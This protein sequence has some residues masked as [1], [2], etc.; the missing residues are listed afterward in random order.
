MYSCLLILTLYFFSAEVGISTVLG[1]A[2]LALISVY[3]LYYSSRYSLFWFL[4]ALIPFASE[5]RFSLEYFLWAAG[6]VGLALSSQWLN[7][8]ARRRE[9]T[10]F[11]A[12]I[13]FALTDY[14]RFIF[15]E[16]GSLLIWLPV[17]LSTI[18]TLSW[19][20]AFAAIAIFYTNKKAALLAYIAYLVQVLFVKQGRRY[21]RILLASG[22]LLVS[23]L[24]LVSHPKFL[25]KFYAQSIISRWH[26]WQATFS[27]FLDQAF[28]GH[29]FGTFAI[30]F[31]VYRQHADALGAR[32]AEHVAH[33]H[34]VPLHF[35]FEQGLV[36]LLLYLLLVVTIYSCQP[37]AL[38][39]F[40]LISFC[41][42][43]LVN[44][45]QYL[46]AALIL[47][48]KIHHQSLPVAIKQVLGVLPPRLL[49]PASYLAC[50]L[51]IVLSSFSIAAHYFYDRSQFTR[52]IA[53]DPYHSLYYF[54]RGASNLHLNA[55]I[56]E[57]D[58]KR[59]VE[60]SP[61]VSYF[62][63]FLAA[64]HLANTQDLS[65][66]SQDP[67]LKLASAAIK[68][69]VLY[70]GNDAYWH[71][72]SSFIHYQNPKLSKAEMKLALK[73]NPEIE[74]LLHEPSMTASEYIGSRKSDVRISGFYR[75]GPKVFL[76]LPY[77]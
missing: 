73:R 67:R 32:I 56:S 20:Q 10:L 52:A 19:H 3:G 60:L 55:A 53:L 47:L 74:S 26:I 27:G 28:I 25:A 43:S 4:L 58:L 11:V 36:G 39:P 17:W 24:W 34:S 18:E 48:P 31:P 21:D 68:K 9:I 23:M 38:L 72:L 51:A 44:L 2:G 30:D 41:D 14:K 69:A 57:V 50:I 77:F 35:L 37:N 13:L 62:Y 65:P 70:D 63:G 29:G 15:C 64:S 5:P 45:N 8:A 61:H 7:L 6:V 42:A 66:N 76:P 46:L 16:Q 49:R 75:R 59:A 1:H 54:M 22:F 40:L 33:G 12:F 71:T